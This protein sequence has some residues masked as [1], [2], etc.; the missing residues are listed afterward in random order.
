MSLEIDALASATLRHLRE[1]WWNDSFAAF[2]EESLR[3]RPG[4]RIL[5][6]G[7]GTGTGEISLSR[8]RLTQIQ[9]YGVDLLLQRLRQA[10]DATRGVNARASY[11]AADACRLPFGTAVFDSTYCVALLQHIRDFA[12][13]LGEMA[14]VTKPNGRILVV[15]PDNAAVYWFSS[16]P[17]GVDAFDLGRRFFAER[18]ATREEPA[19]T[20]VGPQVPGL[21]AAH[22][23]EPRSVQLFP[24]SVSHVGAPPEDVWDARRKAV[25]E[26]ITDTPNE[27]LRRLG[28][29]YLKAIDRY[30]RDAQAAGSTFVEIQNT[31]LFAIAGQ[32]TEA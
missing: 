19:A 20:A 16:L 11:A 17:S 9:L 21:F 2:L 25:K 23:I 4:K 18:A 10:R 24:V 8:L 27:S 29:D 15:E 28:A 30:A 13:A 7:C 31:L 12:Q 22:G 14:R 26:A 3:P 1:R 6:V 5:H 32:R